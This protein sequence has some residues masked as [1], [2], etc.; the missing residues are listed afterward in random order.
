DGWSF[1]QLNQ[2]GH[3]AGRM[4]W[5]FNSL[6]SGR[7]L[8]VAA[9]QLPGGAV[10]ELVRENAFVQAGAGHLQLCPVKVYLASRQ[11]RQTSRMVKMQMPQEHEVDIVHGKLQA[12]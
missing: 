3:M 1:R 2:Q 11:V 6:D 8:I 4:P 7:D 10:R 9:L 5:C 12:L